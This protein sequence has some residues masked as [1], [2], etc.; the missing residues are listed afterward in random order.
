[1]FY[2]RDN[3]SKTDLL[4]LGEDYSTWDFLNWNVEVIED[5]TTDIDSIEELDIYP[6]ADTYD[7]NDVENNIKTTN[8]LIQAVKHLNKEIH[9]IKEK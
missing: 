6:H 5:Q 7:W 2:H 8:I 1:M 3:D 9:S 4:V